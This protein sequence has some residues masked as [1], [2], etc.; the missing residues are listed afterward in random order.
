MKDTKSTKG[1]WFFF[2]SLFSRSTRIIGIRDHSSPRGL[3][4]EH[5]EV[6]LTRCFFVLFVSFVS[7][8][9]AAW[10]RAQKGVD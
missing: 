6:M 5:A 2:Y 7:W 10:Q 4:Q 8:P 1:P 3:H 9:A